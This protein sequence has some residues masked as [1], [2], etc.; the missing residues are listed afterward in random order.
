MAKRKSTKGQT[1]IYKTYIYNSRSSNTNPTKNRGWA[2]V[3]RKGKQFL[4]HERMIACKNDID[5]P[6]VAYN[7]N[8]DEHMIAL[9]TVPKSCN[10]Y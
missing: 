6:I 8:I 4:L 1:T 2:Q 3:L 10:Y 5:E 7:M 9:F